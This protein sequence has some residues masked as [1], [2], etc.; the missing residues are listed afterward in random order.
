MVS[1]I[2]IEVNR[3]RMISNEDANEK[4]CQQILN[5]II[6]TAFFKV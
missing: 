3:L 6:S 4:R 5:N 2:V 1:I